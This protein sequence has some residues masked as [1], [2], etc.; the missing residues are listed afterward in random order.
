MFWTATRNIHFTL[1][2]VWTSWSC[3]LCCGLISQ[4]LGLFVRGSVIVSLGDFSAVAS[5]W[6]HEESHTFQHRWPACSWRA[7]VFMQPGK[8]TAV[9]TLWPGPVIS[10]YCHVWRVYMN[11]PL[12]WNRAYVKNDSLTSLSPQ[13]ITSLLN[14][15][16]CCTPRRAAV[17]V[18]SLWCFHLLSPFSTWCVA[19]SHDWLHSG[20][21]ASL[22][23]TWNK[24]VETYSLTAPGQQET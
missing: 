21:W 8:G 11:T 17:V 19:G 15:L 18:S 4:R 3:P 10:H 23:N 22:G 9:F 5:V 6:Q 1:V 13:S 7:L 14:Y 16:C 24:L 2:R 12:N 20:N